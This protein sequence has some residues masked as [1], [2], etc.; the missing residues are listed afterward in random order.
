MLGNS[1]GEL[2]P[3]GTVI[4]F[5]LAIAEKYLLQEGHRSIM[6]HNDC[7]GN[8]FENISEKFLKTLT[9]DGVDSLISKPGLLV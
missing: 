5:Y 4:W 8:L 3:C 2:V 1:L 7:N 6:D 9:E